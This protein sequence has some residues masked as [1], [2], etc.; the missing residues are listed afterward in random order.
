MITKEQALEALEKTQEHAHAL[1]FGLGGVG[2]F[3]TKED[4]D[5]LKQYITQSGW[6]PHDYE[7]IQKKV[8]EACCDEDYDYRDSFVQGV[9]ATFECLREWYPPAPPQK[10]SKE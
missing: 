2:H 9:F 10:E 6:M 4:V 5:T 7:N 8:L 1:A 3:I